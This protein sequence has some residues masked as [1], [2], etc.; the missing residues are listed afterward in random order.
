M[1]N[2]QLKKKIREAFA[3]GTPDISQ[4]IMMDTLFSDPH[5]QEEAVM[6]SYEQRK[7][8]RFPVFSVAAA[9][10]AAI[11]VL[12]ISINLIANR[13][14]GG[15]VDYISIDKALE[16]VFD[17]PS[18]FPI[19]GVTPTV[20]WELDTESATPHY[21]VTLTYGDSV[22]YQYVVDATTGEILSMEQALLKTDPK[23]PIT[24]EE[25]M[26]IVLKAAQL[27][28][29]QITDSVFEMY[30]VTDNPHYDIT[31][32]SGNAL[33]RYK[34]HPYSGEILDKQTLMTADGI[35]EEMAKDIALIKAQ[36]TA[37][38][39]SNY[40]IE[41][42]GD[43]WPIHYDISFVAQGVIYEFEIHAVSGEILEMEA[44]PTAEAF[45]SQDDAKAIALVSVQLTESQITAYS[46]NFKND[47]R[48]PYYSIV[49][50]ADNVKYNFEIHAIT[51]DILKSAMESVLISDPTPVIVVVPPVSVALKHAGLTKEEVANLE[52]H[53][54]LDDGILHI[55]VSFIAKGLK[56][57]YEITAGGKILDYETE[58]MEDDF[59]SQDKALQLFDEYLNA[60]PALFTVKNI[61]IASWDGRMCYDIIKSIQNGS[62][63]RMKIDAITGALLLKETADGLQPIPTPTPTPPDG[64]TPTGLATSIALKEVGLSS[65]RLVSDFELEE[66][67][68]GNYPHYDISFVFQGVKY[69]FEIGMY[70]GGQILSVEKE[71]V[72]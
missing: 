41:W 1:T 23:D 31:F 16:T 66:D 55:D 15:S 6:T 25:A 22:A 71:P 47:S 26:Q 43:E 9:A 40:C 32:R 36:V 37:D 54:D 4:E 5:M 18:P 13:P 11:A 30:L 34:V 17:C 59:I 63:V 29:S 35:S 48:N 8:I 61:S 49:F 58:P 65:Q 42:D 12:A 2:R 14:Q 50:V 44:E 38:Q 24:L 45:I 70:D 62:D 51:G 69:T 27:D 21:D 67:R 20:E 19:T 33:Y 56:Y 57:E 28:E 46:S 39:I 52:S 7:P 53:G 64:K 72:N 3:H 68:D 10:C 60:S